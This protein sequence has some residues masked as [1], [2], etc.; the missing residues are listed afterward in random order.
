M[1]DRRGQGFAGD[2]SAEELEVALAAL[3]SAAQEIS[4][5]ILAQEVERALAA[6][7]ESG[8]APFKRKAR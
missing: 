6:L 1:L 5:V 4:G 3:R 7:L 8:P 2:S